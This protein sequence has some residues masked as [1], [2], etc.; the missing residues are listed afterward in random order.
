MIFDLLDYVFGWIKLLIYKIVGLKHLQFHLFVK[1]SAHAK[2]R[3]YNKGKIIIGNNAVVRSGCILRVHERGIIELGDGVGLNNNCLLTAFQ[4]ITIGD[5]SIIGQG[6][7]IYDHDHDYGKD[8]KIRYAGHKTA[9]V[10]IGSNTWIGSG[11]IILKGTTIGDNCVI[12]AGTIIKEDIPSNTIVYQERKK[13]E[14]LIKV[15]KDD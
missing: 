11:V 1:F 10:S 2:L 9:S 12:G 4:K 15:K 14:H 13:V 8:E 7:K 3:I 6:V 5:Y